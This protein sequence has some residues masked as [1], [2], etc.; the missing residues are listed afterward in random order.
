MIDLHIHSIHS[1][2]SYSVEEILKEAKK[3]NL[4]YI[5][6]TDHDK[7]SAYYELEKMDIS[8]YYEGKI[9]SG[10]EIK[11]PYKGIAIE[12]LAYGI[13]VKQL[14]KEGVMD[15][16]SIMDKQSKYL[17]Y[18][19]SVGKRIGLQFDES[20][21]VGTDNVDCYASERFEKEIKR[22]PENMEIL[23]KNNISIEPNFY[24]AA[25]ANIVS[26]FYINEEEFLASI[27]KVI[28][29]IHKC[30]GLAFLAHPYLYPF[31][32]KEEMI[33]DMCKNTDIDGLECYYSLFT[34]K[35]IEKL[36]GITKEYN[37]LISGGT[38]FHG[39]NRKGTEMGIGTGNL[40]IEEKV[41]KD[42]IGRVKFF[43]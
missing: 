43:N 28:D 37:K 33:K 10:C 6:I 29:A 4:Q 41:I 42:W 18:F 1:D 22:Y 34:Q 16:D 23:R 3:K 12:I 9:I 19:K 20:I 27:E 15:S 17:E 31:Q 24:R 8:K 21:K 13:D 30:G 26:P 14:E 38:D 35:E 7:V 5:S 2:G 32:N 40:N 36:I 11:T 39:E 25:Q